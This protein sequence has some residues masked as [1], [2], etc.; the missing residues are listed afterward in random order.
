[1]MSKLSGI[2]PANSRILSADLSNAQPTRAG[3]PKFWGGSDVPDGSPK[4]ILATSA[5]DRVSWSVAGKQGMNDSVIPQRPDEFQ[6]GPGGGLVDFSSGAASFGGPVQGSP[7]DVT[8]PADPVSFNPTS[9][10]SDAGSITPAASGRIDF[11][12]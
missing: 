2:L 3:A 4:S 6:N 11:F 8:S 1:M 12:A 10:I 5:L 7:V 9:E